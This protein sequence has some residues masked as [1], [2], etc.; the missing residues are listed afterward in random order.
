M[1]TIRRFTV[2]HAFACAC[3]APAVAAVPLHGQA[4][5]LDAVTTRVETEVTRILAE[6]PIP[7]ISM[8]IVRNGQVEWAGAWGWSNV[9]A[10]VPATTDTYYSTGST[11]K[12]VTATAIMQLVEKGRI[13]LDTPLNEIVPDSLRID[14]ANDVTLRHLLSHHSGL[15]GPVGI[16]PLWERTSPRTVETL[17]AETRRVGEPGT[18]YRYCNECY[19]IAGWVVEKISG[20]SWDE[21]VAESIL[22]PL[23]ID[24]ARPSIPSP[25]AVE[26]LALPY[27]VAD[28]KPSPVAQVRYDVFAAGDVYLRASDMARFLAAQLG[29]GQFGDARILRP[30]SVREMRRGQFAGRAYGLGIGLAEQAGRTILSHGGSIPGFNSLLIGEP[31]SG[32]G[33][34]LMANSGQASSVLNALARLTL[35]LLWGENPEPLSSFATVERV[36][37]DIDPAVFDAYV[38]VYRLSPDFE[39]TVSRDADQFFVQATGQQPFR[40]LAES[41]TKFFLLTV[42]AQVTFG[43]DVPDGPVTHMILHQAGANQRLERIR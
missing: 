9:A 24:V 29:N 34:Y 8:A 40:I 11:F 30:E 20:K 31:A 25:A 26:M 33:V 22:A 23:G 12:F 28:N 42:D 27:V 35:R 17:L 6:T 13:E 14:G 36:E 5:D 37:V 21:Y 32:L 10:R 16:V 7:S 41:D 43:R 38:G 18:E 1:M 15:Q 3:V 4:V 2:M 19:A 39:I